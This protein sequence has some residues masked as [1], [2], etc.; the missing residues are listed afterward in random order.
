MAIKII[1]KLCNGMWVCSS[2]IFGFF[3]SSVIQ[4]KATVILRRNC[5]TINGAIYRVICA[6]VKNL[7]SNN[8]TNSSVR[9]ANKVWG[10]EF[11]WDIMVI[12]TLPNNL[13]KMIDR[14]GW[15]AKIQSLKRLKLS[16]F[17]TK[18]VTF[19]WTNC[20]FY[21]ESKISWILLWNFERSRNT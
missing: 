14:F 21:G 19:Y 9:N 18:N 13:Y 20:R 10:I 8:E 16:L 15:A 7:C 11:L 3:F 5:S 4:L 12:I 2:R 1:M 6:A 17:H